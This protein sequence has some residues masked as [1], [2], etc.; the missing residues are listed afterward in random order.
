[1]YEY[2]FKKIV[3]IE[4]DNKTVILVNKKKAGS[5]IIVIIP[6]YNEH[7]NIFIFK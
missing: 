4:I 1:M 3:S 7:N 6:E 2:N 5:S